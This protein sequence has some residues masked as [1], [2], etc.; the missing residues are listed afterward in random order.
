MKNKIIVLSIIACMNFAF[1]K[2]QTTTRGIKVG[3]IDMD[4]I[5]ENVPEYQQALQE[6]ETKMQ[7]W[8]AEIQT[9][10]TEIEQM[11][12]AL[13]NEKVLL[14]KELTEEKEEDIRIK[15]EDLLSY[16]Q[17]RFAAGGDF[18]LQRLQLIQPVQDQVFNEVQKI[19]ATKKY[20]YIMDV[21]DLGILAAADRHDLSDE[22]LRAI[23]RT[24]KKKER[25]DGKNKGKNP[26]DDVEDEPYLSVIESES[27]ELRE[28]A[29]QDVINEREADRIAK[30]SSR[31][32]IKAAK[33]AAYQERK[34]KLI[35]DRQ[36][37][38]DSILEARQKAKENRTS[39]GGN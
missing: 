36:R 28:Q 39:S 26:V 3:H 14:T 17:K 2:A 15:Q 31:D 25:E 37:R 7:K 9:M 23:G 18:E 35:A 10:K 12:K 6:L 22:V 34:A 29:K 20:D 4:Y 5:L 1:A 8:A 27:K 24:G 11:Q 33:A 19:K 16:Q 30:V 38:K 32:S 21:S 13:Q